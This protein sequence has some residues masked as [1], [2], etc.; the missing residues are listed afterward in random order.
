MKEVRKDA[1]SVQFLSIG[2]VN[3]VHAVDMF[4]GQSQKVLKLDTNWWYYS[5]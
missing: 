4:W 2:R 5:K 3:T 1:Q